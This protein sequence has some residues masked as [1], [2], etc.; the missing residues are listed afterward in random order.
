MNLLPINLYQINWFV[1]NLFEIKFNED[2]KIKSA[3]QSFYG[4]YPQDGSLISL[5]ISCSKKSFE[6]ISNNYKKSESIDY[7]VEDYNKSKNT[8]SVK[9]LYRNEK[10]KTLEFIGPFKRGGTYEE[11]KKIFSFKLLTVNVCSVIV[12][13]IICKKINTKINDKN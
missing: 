12:Y 8:F 7:L 1:V 6:I 9:L 2:V 4:Y 10:L 11:R 13:I 3:D 5:Y